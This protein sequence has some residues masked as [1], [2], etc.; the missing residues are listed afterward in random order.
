[1]A[2]GAVLLAVIHGDSAAIR[3]SDSATAEF[4]TASDEIST[5]HSY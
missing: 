3:I 1:M 2:R 5:D 4:S